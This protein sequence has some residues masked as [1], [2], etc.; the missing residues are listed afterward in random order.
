METQQNQY[1][2]DFTLSVAYRDAACGAVYRRVGS[3]YPCMVNIPMKTTHTNPTCPTC[4]YDLA[5][6]VRED[7]TATCPQCAS[8]SDESTR[9]PRTFAAAMII[10]FGLLAPAILVPVTG[11]VLISVLNWDSAQRFASVFIPLALIAPVVWIPAVLLTLCTLYMG[12]SSKG[13]TKSIILVCVGIIP[14]S[15]LVY[16]ILMFIVVIMMSGY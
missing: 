10:A 6:I 7:D 13:E 12:R 8:D 5:G 1:Q 3:A 16:C 14:L 9:W 15:V 4:G 11:M 2:T